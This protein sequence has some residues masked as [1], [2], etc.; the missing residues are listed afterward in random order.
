MGTD[1]I[2]CALVSFLAAGV[3]TIR[4]VERIAEEFGHRVCAED[5]V[6]V[7]VTMLERIAVAPQ[8]S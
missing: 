8:R 6:S 4:C 7:A 5:G 3:G 1:R 2:E